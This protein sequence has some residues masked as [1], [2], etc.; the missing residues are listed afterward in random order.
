MKTTKTLTLILLAIIFFACDDDNNT[1]TTPD[2]KPTF[3]LT[4]EFT[5][6]TIESF[7]NNAVAVFRDSIV[8]IGGVVYGNPTQKTGGAHSFRNNGLWQ[9]R[10]DK[11]AP[12]FNKNAVVFNQTLYVF[13]SGGAFEGYPS[14]H[15]VFYTTDMDTWQNYIAPFSIM[16]YADAVVWNNKMVMVGSPSYTEPYQVWTT[17]NGQDW[18]NIANNLNFPNAGGKLA[19]FNNQL[20]WVGGTRGSND[21]V[22][23]EIW[24]STDGI[25]WNQITTNAPEIFGHGLVVYNN[26]LFIVGGR[27]DNNQTGIWY[28]SNLNEWHPAFP[29]TASRADYILG[30]G[31]VV[32]QG[33]IYI[34]GGFRY[35][36]VSNTLDFTGDITALVEN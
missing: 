10:F 4:D 8:A 18:Q 33:K 11:I 23:N 22:V 15:P 34:L 30:H 31:T 7:A 25:N 27:N 9:E 6:S 16:N 32:Y 24:T 28:S 13:G 14:Q 29:A 1:D 19:V 26:K 12:S 36:T 5:S 35:D 2:I 21:D 3:T 20:V 17:S